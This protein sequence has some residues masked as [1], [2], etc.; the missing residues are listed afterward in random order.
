M[1]R[2]YISAINRLLVFKRASHCCEYCK[3]PADYSTE[4]FSVEHIIPLVKDGLNDLINLALSCLGCNYNKSTK[5]AF[6]DPISQSI[7]PLFNPRT[8]AW[9]EHFMWDETFT[10]II[11]QTA[12][13]RV[14]V[15]ALKLNRP[16]LRNLRRALIAIDEHP[17][18]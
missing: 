14:T 10:S 12:I 17:P 11:G 8:M 5:T 15:L 9:H 4:P 16:Q 6:F 3:C 18:E 2:P 1:A 13:G 7:T